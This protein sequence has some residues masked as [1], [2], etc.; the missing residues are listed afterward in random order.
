MG[1]AITDSADFVYENEVMQSDHLSIAII[2]PCAN[3]MA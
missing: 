1:G 3:S 2:C